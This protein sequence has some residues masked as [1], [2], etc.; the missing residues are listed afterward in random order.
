MT[1]Q[2]TGQNFKDEVIDKSKTT[3]VLV[4]FYASWCGPCQMQ[5]PIIEE[6]SEELKEKAVIGKLSTEEYPEIAANYGIMSIPTL[7]IFKD[8]AVVE[9][10]IGLRDKESLIQQIEKYV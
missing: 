2:F 3:P 8:G 6:L 4:D 10:M 7:L 1:T 9:E 5:A